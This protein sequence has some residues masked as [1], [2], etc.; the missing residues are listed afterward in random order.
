MIDISEN[1]YNIK[2][3]CFIYLHQ[4]LTLKSIK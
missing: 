4:C 3:K 2:E 1:N